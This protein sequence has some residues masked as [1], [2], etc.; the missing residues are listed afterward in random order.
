MTP[1]LLRL[2]RTPE[3]LNALAAAV[4]VTGGE[5]LAAASAMRARGFGADLAAAA[6]TQASLRA[7]AAMK[8]GPDAARMFFTRAGLEQATR[9]PVADRRAARLAAS[10]VRTLADL[11]CGLGSDALAAARH[12]ISVYAVDADP[13]TAALAAANAEAAGLADLITVACAD[14]T[15]VPVERYDA[16]FADP[17]RRQAGRGRVFDPKAY[18]P[19]WDFIAAL[20][21]RVPR[22]VL[23]LAPGIDHTLLPPGAEGEWVSAGGDLVEA[24]FWCGPLAGVPRRATLIGAGVT[25]ITGS[26]VERAPVG[27]VGAWIYDPDPAVVRSHLVA[28]FAASVG[29]RLGDPDIA[30]VYTDDPVDTPFA[31]RLAVTEVLPFSL[32]RLRALLRDRGVGVLEIR[33]RGSALV[34]DQL[35]KDLR[36]A[37]PNA[38]GLV[39]TRVDG[40]PVVLLTEMA[41]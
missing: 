17:A 33:K 38:A 36:L 16:I 20:P 4:E 22:T 30:Y 7:R 26:G 19:P 23:K 3:G 29:G 10:G 40:A 35:R 6:L 2:L 41:R 11:G 31:R 1:E 5:P 28:E 34:P 37:G 9:G 25:E 12:G 14:A 27:P 15:T 18:S 13:L 21:G 32:K 39:L 24:A 8:F